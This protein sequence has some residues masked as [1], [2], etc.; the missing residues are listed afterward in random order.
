MLSAFTTTGITSSAV[1]NV[2][3]RSPQDKHSRRRRI[4]RPSPARRESFTLVS[5]WP[6][7]GQYT[8][9]LSGLLRAVHREAATQLDDLRSHALDYRIGT[10]SVENLNDEVCHL[11]D[12]RLL[13]ATGR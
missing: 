8:R 2:V 4:C 11:L 7:N 3:N 10:L 5:T 9:R 13:E 1:S 12:L 6:Q